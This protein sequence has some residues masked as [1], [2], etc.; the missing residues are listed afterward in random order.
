MRESR[1]SGSVEGVVGNHDSYSDSRLRSSDTPL[2]AWKN[3]QPACQ[4]GELLR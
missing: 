2:P 3:E 4:G 1:S